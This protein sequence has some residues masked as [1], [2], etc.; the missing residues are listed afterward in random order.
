[1]SDRTALLAAICAHPDEDTPRLVFADWCDEHG[2]G[3]RAAFIR[4][5]IEYHRLR[6]ADTAAPTG[7]QSIRSMPF[8]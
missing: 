7:A 4:A 1:M 8:S 6:A 5:R 3:K 2:E